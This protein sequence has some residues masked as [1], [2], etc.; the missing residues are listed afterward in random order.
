MA[1]WIFSK[2]RWKHAR[3]AVEALVQLG[4]ALF[5]EL[6]IELII[7]IRV[8]RGNQVGSAVLEGHACHGQR[9]V[10]GFRAVV[11]A[12]KDVAVNIDQIYILLGCRSHGRRRRT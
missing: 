12:P 9:F 4:E 2:L 5:N 1:S 11:H 3:R 10:Q 6:N 7:E 8:R